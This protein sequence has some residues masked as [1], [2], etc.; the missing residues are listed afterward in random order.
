[1]S[2]S[3][4]QPELQPVHRI[5]LGEM[6][7]FVFFFAA[8]MS[9]LVGALNVPVANAAVSLVCCMPV[10]VLS[11]IWLA[12][13]TPTQPGPRYTLM[14]LSL[15]PTLLMAPFVV[16]SS[17][18]VLKE[19]KPDSQTL[20]TTV[21]SMEKSGPN[22]TELNGRTLMDVANSLYVDEFKSFDE[23]RTG[24]GFEEY[25]RQ[26][27]VD[28]KYVR[29]ATDKEA[30]LT[31]RTSLTFEVDDPT[32][33]GAYLFK[34]TLSQKVPRIKIEYHQF[35]DRFHDELYHFIKERATELQSLR[36]SGSKP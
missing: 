3:E 11:F 31:L 27:T 5:F 4:K 16:A 33:K 29:T 17:N 19:M 9:V 14:M 30:E 15:L 7:V 2:S 34:V 6:F 36:E 13:T 32:R 28:R 24:W 10:W 8:V 20:H 26:S 35:S 1:M 23:F 12:F 22:S 25:K 21:L 18:S